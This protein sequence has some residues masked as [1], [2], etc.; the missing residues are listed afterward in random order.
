MN[1][2]WRIRAT[3]TSDA[4]ASELGELL[5]RGGVDHELATAAGERVVVSVDDRHVFLYASTREQAERAAEALA[6]LAGDR[7]WEISTELR[8]WH[9]AAEEWKDPD[10]P[11]PSTDAAVEQE[12]AELIERERLESARLGFSE[13]EVRIACRSHRD[14]IEL[15]NRLRSEGIPY[16]RRWRYLLVGAS[17]EQSAAALAERLSGE[18]PAGCTVN[19]EA[20]LAAVN[21]EL[22]PNPFAVFGGLGG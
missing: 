21:A 16:L 17:D 11:L 7:G 20:S 4:R 19:V 13:Y 15:A 22:P 9:P 10:A 2:D 18:V 5:G 12:H 1:D 6:K 3:V 8:R 14:T